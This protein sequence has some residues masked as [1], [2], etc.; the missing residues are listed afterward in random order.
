MLP[1]LRGPLVEREALFTRLDMG[2]EQ[3]VLLLSAPA[4]SGKTTLVRAWLATRTENTEQSSLTRTGKAHLLLVTRAGES[5]LPPVAWVTLEAGENDPV[6]FWR[7]VLTACQTIQPTLGEHALAMLRSQQQSSFESLLTIFLNELAQSPDQ[8]ILVLEDYHTITS[9]LVHESLAFLL[10]HLPETLRVI[11]ITRGDPPLPLARWRAHHDLCELRAADLRFS[12]E[13]TRDFLQQ[14]LPFSITPATLQ[15]LHERVEGW[16]AGL[17]LLTLALQGHRDQHEIEQVLTSFSGGQ[18]H[19]LEY[20]VADVLNAQPE[21]TQQFLLQ[22][23][24]LSRLSGSLCDALTGR[25]DSAQTLAQLDQANLFLYPLDA[26]GEWYRYQTL[27][28][29]AMQHEARRRL[30]EEHWLELYGKASHW[31]EQ[32]AQ[33]LDAIEA[34]L[35]ARDFAR[36]ADLMEHISNPLVFQNEYHTFL[37]FAQQLPEEQLEAHP[38]LCLIYGSGLL[39]LFD[40]RAPE[41]VA[42]VERPLQIAEWIWQAED[43][44]IGLGMVAAL[45]S[46]VYWWQGNFPQAFVYARQALELLPNDELMWRGTCLIHLGTAELFA[47]RLDEA[48]QMFAEAQ[49]ATRTIGNAY[50]ARAAQFMLCEIQLQRGELRLVAQIYQQILQEA[51]AQQDFSDASSICSGLALL[52]YEWNRLEMTHEGASQGLE[53]A[54][55]FSDTDVLIKATLALALMQ[56]AQG[57]TVQAEQ[58]LTTLAAQLQRWPYYLR[59]IHACHARI[60]LYSGDIAAAEQQIATCASCSM[61]DNFIHQ[62]ELALLNAR[63]LLARNNP[64]EA[65]TLLRDWQTQVEEHGFVRLLLEILVIQTLAYHKQHEASQAQQVLLRAL[66][67]ARPEGYQR[68]FLDGGSTLAEI[69]RALLP[70]IHSEQ[71]ATYVRELLR[72]F[73]SEQ[74]TLTSSPTERTAEAGLFEPLS[75]QEKRVLRL[76]AAGRTNPEIA[77]ELIVSVNTIKTQVQSIYTKLGVNSRQQAREAAQRLKLV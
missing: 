15:K 45:R 8:G 31:Y 52:A 3:R 77:G 38:A 32:H 5:V 23:S 55:R 1:R 47:G 10:D 30:G 6:R 24:L 58:D 72:A 22:T 67:L 43:N 63:L 16:A 76:L 75:P 25:Q 74:T 60:A 41:T 18:Q 48:Q 29:E 64:D 46:S 49:L 44:K 36:A 54:R 35:H 68:L 73:A 57:E 7:Y 28:A 20:L 53:I 13:E 40:R 11:L 2:L 26:A 37:Q 70:T 17:R 50:A 59:E 56:H 71:V 65:L 21:E 61:P 14:A 42:Q 27:F 51:E 39:Y 4:G 34:A 19:I 62:A 69:L 33:P 12:L 66:T 9:P